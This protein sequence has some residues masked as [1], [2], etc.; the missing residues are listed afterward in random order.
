MFLLAWLMEVDRRQ[1]FRSTLTLEGRNRRQ[2]GLPRHA[3]LPPTASAWIQLYN[4]GSDQALI[5]V[6]GFDHATFA[7]ML[8]LFEGW[9]NS[10][11]PWTGSQDGST[12]RELSPYTHGR[13]RIIDARTC[14]G[15]V[16]AWYRFRGAEY[17]LQG[18]FGY[19]GAHA[20]VWLRFGRRGLFLALYQNPLAK[21]AMPSDANIAVLKS[22]VQ[23]RHDLL[24]DVFAFADGVK[25]YFESTG[26]L[27]EQSM[28]YNG[29]KSSHFITNL[30]VFSSDGR[31]ISTV[32]NAPGSLHDS[33]LAEWGGVYSELE[34]VYNRTG[35]KCCVDSAFSTVNNA[36][37]IK[38]S[39]N[40]GAA[41]DGLNLLRMEQATSLRQAAEWGMRAIQ[42]AFPRLRDRIHFEENGERAVFLSLVPLL[43]NY[44]LAKV[45]LNQIRN[46]YCPSW[47]VDS[48][49]F[50][51]CSDTA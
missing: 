26:D 42:S 36:F 13:N 29:W 2:R 16:L 39:Q 5:T 3:L 32:V 38:S 51:N 11:T 41:E 47:S 7:S 18:W 6:T 43:Y 44:R 4:S 10:H 17:I 9:F 21:V 48:A 15:L 20:N 46:V 27:D 19:T 49:F 8:G 23:A 40:Y 35:A 30:F 1:S 14:L 33:T 22:I 50:I 45:G 31:C 28:Y 34:R 24:T 25:L 12:F 37:L